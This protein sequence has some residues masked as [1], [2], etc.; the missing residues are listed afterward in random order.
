MV[1]VLCLGLL[2]GGCGT[3]LSSV[4]YLDQARAHLEAGD[5]RAAIIALKNALSK[6]PDL[7]EAR[8]M[9][10]RIY[11]QHDDPVS[12]EKELRK[13]AAL[14]VAGEDFLDDLVSALL[15]QKKWA[16]ALQVLQAAPA[17]AETCIGLAL[18][19]RVRLAQD[20]VADAVRAFEGAL[21]RDAHCGQAFL[22]LAR[23]AL[24]RGNVEEAR[25]NLGAA[26]EALGDDF[27]LHLL[28]SEIALAER[29]PDVAMSAYR[30]AIAAM[31]ENP[32][33]RIAL[34]WVMVHEDQ[35]DEALGVLHAIPAQQRKRYPAAQFLEGTIRFRKEDFAKAREHLVAAERAMPDYPPL[36][37]MLGG[38]YAALG[39]NEQAMGYLRK[40][41]DRVP[42]DKAA[43]RLLLRLQVAA[44]R[45][46]QALGLL[47]D[48]AGLAFMAG[49]Y[50]VT[51]GYLR[52]L[53]TAGP[54]GRQAE[55][56]GL[57][58]RAFLYQGQTESAIAAFRN[59]MELGEDKTKPGLQLLAIHLREGDL[60]RALELVKELET[61]APED[62]AV[63]NASGVVLVALEERAA[64]RRQFERAL[65]LDDGYHPARLNLARLDLLEGDREAARRR[66]L[67][68]L[69]RDPANVGARLWLARLAAATGDRAAEGRW[70]REAHAQAPDHPLVLQLLLD[71]ELVAGRLDAAR[72]LI[73]E[74]RKQ[75]PAAA[76]LDLA[77]MRLMVREGR[78]ESAVQL[79][80]KSLQQHPAALDVRGLLG[81]LYLRLGDAA[82]AEQQFSAL[83]ETRPGDARTRALLGGLALARGDRAG[84]RR[85]L[86]AL[87]AQG[88][89]A[90]AALLRGDIASTEGEAAA[91]FEAYRAAWSRAPSQKTLLKMLE[92]ARAAKAPF[93]REAVE[94]WLSSHPGD[95]A[96]RHRLARY[97]ARAGRPDDAAA[98]YRT[99]LEQ[100]PDDVVALNNLA[101][102][103]LGQ[104]H[105]EAARALARKALEVAPGQVILKDTLGW[106]EAKAGRPEAGLAL[107]DEVLA[108]YPDNPEVLLH[109]A[110]VLDRLGREAQAGRVLRRAL[111]VM[112]AGGVPPEFA[113]LAEKYR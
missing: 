20:A 70:L 56:A 11:L 85:Q 31:P 15:G 29:K 110:W 44:G 84:A 75:F 65:E 4:E 81:R 73:A 39:E 67:E 32:R 100:R 78:I 17:S 22:G 111:A 68:V 106:I 37:L 79:G 52:Q 64:A 101:L 27:D 82:K 28:E 12:A 57:M 16:E 50:D 13:A 61:L 71:H 1:L 74:G 77:E 108:V 47:E 102:V 93:P 62:P 14:G 88:A 18:Q 45:S 42:T 69:A 5:S 35:L 89:Q 59:M 2:L 23:V 107:L 55:L 92:A 86:A 96:V 109:K 25:R 46:D 103:E 98:A 53:Q 36:M 40:Y 3:D 7:A 97:L 34:A 90:L 41:L 33:P 91:A 6:D 60:E 24:Q 105:P 21:Q 76:F 83:L 87:E 95:R 54:K 26:R 19:G 72:T 66:Y 99:L 80:E 94:S 49:R 104:G 63:V 58:G 112:P 38:T 113:E 9:L 43:L 10:G 8:W 51:T 48:R 30:A